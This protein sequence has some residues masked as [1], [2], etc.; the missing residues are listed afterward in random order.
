MTQ[1]KRALCDT[2]MIVVAGTYLYG[3]Y[4][5][6]RPYLYAAAP[7]SSA[8][9]LDAEDSL[10]RKQKLPYKKI[11]SYDLELIKGIGPSIATNLLKARASILAECRSVAN[12]RTAKVPNTLEEN[13][14]QKAHGI[15]SKRSKQLIQQ[16]NICP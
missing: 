7:A 6:N 1:K 3:A 10:A 13:L 15:G 16:L 4:L 11:S 2:I 14:L 8:Q 5:L 12:N 9:L